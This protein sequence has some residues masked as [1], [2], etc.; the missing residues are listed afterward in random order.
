[1]QKNQYFALCFVVLILCQAFALPQQVNLQQ[2]DDGRKFAE[3][4]NAMKKVALDDVD[5][6]STNSIQVRGRCFFFLIIRF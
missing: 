3:K 1:M 5:D 6:I 4:P 2:I